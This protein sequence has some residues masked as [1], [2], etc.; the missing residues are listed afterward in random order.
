MGYI[1]VKCGKT[2]N[3]PEGSMKHPYCKRCF[4]LTWDS[5]E[6]YFFFLNNYHNV[7]FGGVARA[8]QDFKL[9]KGKGK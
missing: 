2:T 6:E 8:K 7:P 4:D 1:C 3:K 9:L 5:M